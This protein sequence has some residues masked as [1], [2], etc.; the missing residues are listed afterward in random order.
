M[1]FDLTIKHIEFFDFRGMRYDSLEDAE[2]ARELYLKDRMADNGCRKAEPEDI[3]KDAIVFVK[4]DG[5]Y[6]PKQI[7]DVI[8]PRSPYKA[9]HASDGCRYGLDRLFVLGEEGDG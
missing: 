5:V 6:Y 9:F 7:S 1:G 8:N 3:V 2:E 4:V